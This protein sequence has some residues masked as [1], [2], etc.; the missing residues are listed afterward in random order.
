MRAGVPR[1]EERGLWG[2]SEAGMGV[3][4]PTPHC[5]SKGAGLAVQNSPKES[6]ASPVVSYSKN[7]F[8]TS[9]WVNQLLGD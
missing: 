9:P 7:S 6:P 3:P 1:S 8:P 4:P 2:G 5:P